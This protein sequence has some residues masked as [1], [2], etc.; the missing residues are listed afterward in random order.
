MNCLLPI[1]TSSD[2]PLHY[3]DTPIGLLFEYHNLHRLPDVY[4][5]AALLI[6]M[7]MDNRKRL[8]IPDN[9]A[10]VIRAG[11]ANLRYSE[12]K[13]S[14]AI[15]IGGVK[16]IAL[17]GHNNC[18]MVK[19]IHKKRTICGRSRGARRLGKRKSR[20]TFSSICASVRN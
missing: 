12:F 16:A 15:A 19:G 14:F 10:Y 2:I 8:R 6:G 13:V 1:S 11:G 20:G 18:G 3:Q 5:K 17:V 4:N 9:F 7:C